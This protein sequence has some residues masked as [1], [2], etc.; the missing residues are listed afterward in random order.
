MVTG[1]IPIFL[2][3]APLWT[4]TVEYT[5][6]EAAMGWLKNCDFRLTSDNFG[7]LGLLLGDHL[8]TMGVHKTPF[9]II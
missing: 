5:H 8:V 7:T 2:R 4:P 3:S 9:G 6:F 1:A